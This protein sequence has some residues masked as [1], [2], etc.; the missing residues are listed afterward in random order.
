MDL[1]VYPPFISDFTEFTAVSTNWDTSDCFRFFRQALL[2]SEQIQKMFNSSLTM[3]CPTRQAFAQFN[4]EDFQ[5]LLEPIWRRHASEFLLNHFTSPALTR[6]ELVNRAPSMITMLNGHEYELKRSGDR[7]RIKN[8]DTEQAR[9]EF[10]DIIALDGYLH[11]IDSAL[12]PTAVSRSIYDQSNENPDFSLLVENI[13]FVQLTDIVDRYLPLTMLAPNNKAFRR[14]TFGTLDGAEI[15]KRHIFEGLLFCDVIA[16]STE[17]TTTDGLAIAV[18]LRGEPGSGLWG[19]KEQ[20]L[21]VGGA[22]IYDCDIFARNGV[23]HHVDRV[24]G[25]DYDTEA[26]SISAGP[27]MSSIPTAGIQDTLAPQNIPTKVPTGFLPIELPPILPGIVPTAIT[28]DDADAPEQA[29]VVST[30]CSLQALAVF[31]TA[32]WLLA[33]L[34]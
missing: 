34:F 32:F 10:G 11:I 7:V 19:P 21:Y 4:N 30:A 3:F 25:V 9:T 22:L 33:T 2:S 31:P 23:L 6:E 13:D 20:N 16:N 24:I 18:E 26:P 15:I 5:R 28:A 29:P 17:I 1:P 14:I 27:S 12:T 8:T